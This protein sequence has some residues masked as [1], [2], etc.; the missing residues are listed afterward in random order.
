MPQQPQGWHPERIKA[1]LRVRYGSLRDIC[2]T[3]GLYQG[4]ISSVLRD[5]AHSILTEKR[6]ALALGVLPQELWPDR[7][8]ADGQ[9]LPRPSKTD[10]RTVPVVSQRKKMRAA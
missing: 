9:P 6:I 10:H 4:A 1:E 8:G 5:P 3:W 2:R 7:W